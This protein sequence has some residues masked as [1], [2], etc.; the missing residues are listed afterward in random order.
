M[1]VSEIERPGFGAGADSWV[2]V[3]GFTPSGPTAGACGGALGGASGR[4]GRVPAPRQIAF[5]SAATSSAELGRSSGSSSTSRLIRSTSW[6]GGAVR[7]C[8]VHLVDQLR[9]VDAL[10][11]GAGH[12]RRPAAGIAGQQLEHD[13]AEGVEVGPSVELGQPAG[14]LGRD[15]A[16]RAGDERE[17]AEVEAAG[18]AEVAEHD[19]LVG[20][21][22]RDV[23]TGRRRPDQHV[24][25]LDVAVQ[26]AG[27]VDV[28]E[29]V[30]HLDGDADHLGRLE[31]AALPATLIDAVAERA[32]VG[33]RHDEV[34]LTGVGLAE[35]E[36][37]DDARAL[38]G[39]Q[40]ASL[41]QE[42]AA[43]LVVAAPVVGEDLDGHVA[44]E[45]VVAGQP[46]RGERTGT[47]DALQSVRSNHLRVGHGPNLGDPGTFRPRPRRGHD[48]WGDWWTSK[49][50]NARAGWPL[51]GTGPRST[52]SSSASGPSSWG[53]AGSSCPTRSTP[54]RPLR[55]RCSSIARRIETFEGR[56]KFTTWMY[57]LTTN[58]AIDCYRK[59]KRRRSVL[60]T[61]PELAAGGS[62]PSVIAGARI[63]LLEAAEQL[64]ERL[65]EP[66]FM[67]DLCELE[68]ADIAEL[69]DV[70]VGT[71][72]SRIHDGRAKLRHALYG[73]Q[74]GETGQDVASPPTAGVARVLMTGADRASATTRVRL[75]AGSLVV[76]LGVVVA[77]AAATQV[78]AGAGAPA[79]DKT[80][81]TLPP[82]SSDVP[83]THDGPHGQVESSV[84][85]DRTV[86]ESTERRRDR[87]SR[88]SPASRR[89]ASPLSAGAGTG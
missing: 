66:V 2:P 32:A 3:S 24:G 87:P 21:Q 64:D 72:K 6:R 10:R 8:C 18:E 60:E 33:P 23:A 46:H 77:A 44:V 1:S 56:A 55:T 35:V 89:A 5:S 45:H 40:H 41:G 79:P 76:A 28:V 37:T 13:A 83:A 15:V 38:D 84:D 42:A 20:R 54:R 75:G 62:S 53:D 73:S 50:S 81:P 16:G 63:D 47:Q 74:S 43:H 51:P 26:V 65:V 52:V 70:P 30:G 69:L 82:A 7:P 12:R 48:E 58:A 71:I 78:P 31:R 59:L 22:A 17:R 11:R 25:R 4:P 34:R 27:A 29:R 19:R 68:Y 67:R 80:I 88:R 39:E 14:L 86:T 85:R 36:P 57:Q 9:D 49:R 61:P